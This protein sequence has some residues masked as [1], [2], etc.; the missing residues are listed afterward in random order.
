MVETLEHLLGLKDRTMVMFGLERAAR[1]MDGRWF[2]VILV[3]AIITLFLIFLRSEEIGQFL[4]YVVG[5]AVVI[6]LT[7]RRA[8]A[9]ED[10]V[11]LA[12]KGQAVTRFESAVKLLESSNSAIVVGA[13]YALHRMATEETEYRRPVFDVL[14]ELI[15]EN[16]QKQFQ[17]GREIAVKILFST[18]SEDGQ[19]VYPFEGRLKGAKLN[20]WDLSGL[21]FSGSDF[22]GADLSNVSFANS[23]LAAANLTCASVSGLKVNERTNCRGVRFCGVH[24]SSIVFREVDMSKTDFRAAGAIVTQLSFVNFEGCDFRDACFDGAKLDKVT[25]KN[26][27]HW[28]P[29]Q[30]TN[31]HLVDYT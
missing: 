26:C 5:G 25:F 15:R 29:E 13:V 11:S 31:A 14:C 1:W 10:N 9:M 16:R 6:W 23:I 3:G 12:Q 19:K 30:L 17:S 28:T 18:K 27:K 20:G 8:K 4:S 2:P 21:D 24:L 7:D 22:E